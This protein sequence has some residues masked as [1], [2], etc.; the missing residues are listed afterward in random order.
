M[1]L[2]TIKKVMVDKNTFLDC[3]ILKYN[4]IYF[5]MNEFGVRFVF[6]ELKTLWHFDQVKCWSLGIVVWIVM[7]FNNK[8][9]DCAGQGRLHKISYPLVKRVFCSWFKKADYAFTG[10]T[11]Y[12]FV[13]MCH[14]RCQF[15]FACFPAPV[16]PFTDQQ[17]R[18]DHRVDLP[19]CPFGIISISLL[20]GPNIKKKNLNPLGLF[21]K[22]E[23]D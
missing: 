8:V 2:L 13:V 1:Y 3:L 5:R 11:L 16:H 20:F 23:T 7:K 22:I 9:I 21:T 6:R 19:I 12:A 14:C 17:K 18:M 10:S 4:A 15:A